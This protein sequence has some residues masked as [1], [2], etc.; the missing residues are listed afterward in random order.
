MTGK[1]LF[2]Y[3]SHDCM[4]LECWHRPSFL[5][6]W[7]KTHAPCTCTAVLEVLVECPAMQP[8]WRKYLHLFVQADFMQMFRWQEDLFDV[9][10][11]IC[12]CASMKLNAL[13]Y[14]A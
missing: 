11:Y 1:G 8:V 14:P 9:A 12:A 6:T 7:P 3:V 5:E 13:C 10:C 4:L 2:C